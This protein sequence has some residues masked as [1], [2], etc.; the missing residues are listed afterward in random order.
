MGTNVGISIPGSIFQTPVN[1]ESKGAELDIT[2]RINEN[3]SVIAN[4]SYTDAR[5]DQRRPVPAGGTP[6]I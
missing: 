3:W 2:G 4:A 6:T 1:V 5:H